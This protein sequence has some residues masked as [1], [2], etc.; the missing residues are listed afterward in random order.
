MDFDKGECKVVDKTEKLP[1]TKCKIGK[2][3]FAL[4]I[5]IPFIVVFDASNSSKF[6]IKSEKDYQTPQF[7]QAGIKDGKFEVRW[8]MVS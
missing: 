4:Y 8:I 2:F 3:L 6:L 5:L 1:G 7:L